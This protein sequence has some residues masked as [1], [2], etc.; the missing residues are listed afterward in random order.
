LP[1]ANRSPFFWHCGGEVGLGAEGTRGLARAARTKV[2]GRPRVAGAWE[3]GGMSSVTISAA[4]LRFARSS[5]FLLSRPVRSSNRSP[6]RRLP[7]SGRRFRGQTL[8]RRQRCAQAGCDVC[9]VFMGRTTGGALRR[10]A[11]GPRGTIHPRGSCLLRDPRRAGAK[12]TACR[13]EALAKAGG[14]PDGPTRMFYCA[15]RAW[16]GLARPTRR[17]VVKCRAARRRLQYS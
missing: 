4:A 2:G 15:P 9:A 5:D 14:I 17:A 3:R 11:G 16:Q 1:V 12:R 10:D 6:W 13:A 7:A 8:A